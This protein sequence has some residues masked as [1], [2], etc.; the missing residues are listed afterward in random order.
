MI[1]CHATNITNDCAVGKCA[2]WGQ[3]NWFVLSS[4]VHEDTAELALKYVS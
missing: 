4:S 3:D 2:V 1:A